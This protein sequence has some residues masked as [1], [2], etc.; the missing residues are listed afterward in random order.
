MKPI[1]KTST[2]I[3]GKKNETNSPL[4]KKSDEEKI[5]N[6][7]VGSP[8]VFPFIQGSRFPLF[9]PFMLTASPLS[10]HP[11]KPLVPGCEARLIGVGA[12][13]LKGGSLGWQLRVEVKGLRGGT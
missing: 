11:F 6:K 4:N 2:K 3:T 9:I 1:P 10:C 5:L 12:E 8:E 7:R 13:G